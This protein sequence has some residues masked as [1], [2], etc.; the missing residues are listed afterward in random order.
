MQRTINKQKNNT[1]TILNISIVLPK[2]LLELWYYIQKLL[3]EISGLIEI[4]DYEGMNFT[5]TGQSF[6]A[7]IL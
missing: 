2:T 4:K 3:L 7:M 6:I 1:C 5:N